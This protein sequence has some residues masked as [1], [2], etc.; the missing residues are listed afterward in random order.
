MKNAKFLST[1]ERRELI[2]K[3]SLNDTGIET[4]FTTYC[5]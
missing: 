2:I 4:L 3:P 1:N 5:E